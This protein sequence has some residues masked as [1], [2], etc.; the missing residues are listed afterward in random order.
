MLMRIQEKYTSRKV[1]LHSAL[2]LNSLPGVRWNKDRAKTSQSSSVNCGPVSRTALFVNTIVIEVLTVPTRHGHSSLKIRLVMCTMRMRKSSQVISTVYVPFTLVLLYSKFVR[3]IRPN[4]QD[5]NYSKAL[6]N[7]PP[8]YKRG[9]LRQAESTS[10]FMVLEN[11][12]HSIRKNS[13]IQSVKLSQATK[14]TRLC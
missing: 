6:L 2:D 14:N 10:V 13:C 1:I 7:T 3:Q 8:Q 12:S 4:I 11:K 9:G 5:H